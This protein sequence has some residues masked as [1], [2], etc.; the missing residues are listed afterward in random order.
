M[1]HGTLAFVAVAALAVIGW[2]I[3]HH[4][5]RTLPSLW[6]LERL[7]FLVLGFAL[8]ED[9]VGLLPADLTSVLEPVVLI[10][11]AWIGLVYGLGV[12]LTT[13][14][15]LATAV[16]RA[17]VLLPLIPGA[18][19]GLGAVAWGRSPLECVALAALAM[20]ATPAYLDRASRQR[21]P[22]DRG[23]LR[24]LRVVTALAGAPALATFGIGA[25]LLSGAASPDRWRWAWEPTIVAAA[26]GAVAAYVLISLVRSETDQVTVLALLLGVTAFV[27]GLA[28]LIGAPGLC[29]ATITG[30]VFTN[31]CAFPHR[32]LREAH[33]LE[34]PLLL[35]LLILVGAS[36]DEASFSLPVFLL[37]AP[38]RAAGCML[39]GWIL[40]HIAW[41]TGSPTRVPLLGLGLLTQ[42]PLAIGLVVA[43]VRTGAG[44]SMSGVLEAV[45]AANVVNH[46]I[47]AL[48]ARRV[49]LAPR[50][51][52]QARST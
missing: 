45:V 30:A 24:L 34:L 25:S 46:T 28:E 49:L 15:R 47:T 12:D 22:V 31:R 11:L 35:A 38:V 42:G 14:G 16:R 48:W 18:L 20:T 10:A 5:Q 43:L 40:A 2:E 6:A 1:L 44:G 27:A 21:R 19:V 51:D 29:V 9:R 39:A 37:L 26:L 50:Q 36:W 8:A 32:V 41:I 52:R 23:S 3:R 4:R 13:L 33:R 17:A 7:A